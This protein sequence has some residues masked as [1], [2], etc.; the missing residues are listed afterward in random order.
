MPSKYERYGKNRIVVYAN[1]NE[2]QDL[3]EVAEA[4]HAAGRPGMLDAEG[5]A[6]QSAVVRH[7]IKQAK[8]ELIVKDA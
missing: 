4:L 3:Q 6:V 7:L 5:K 1:D 8:S 2:K